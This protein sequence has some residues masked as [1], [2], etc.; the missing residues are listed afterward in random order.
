MTTKPMTIKD[1][2][3]L[4]RLH[5]RD[6]CAA[7]LSGLDCELDTLRTVNDPAARELWSQTFC[8]ALWESEDTFRQFSPFEFHAAALNARR[9][10][11]SGWA[12]Y[13]AAFLAGVRE[14]LRHVGG[15]SWLL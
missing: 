3:A 4:G 7:V 8:D 2:R 14:N 13:D 12:A 6:L 10:P 9:D 11:E 15:L 5:G 1:A